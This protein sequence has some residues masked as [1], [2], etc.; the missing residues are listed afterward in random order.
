[1]SATKTAER[2]CTPLTSQTIS[3]HW[4]END[5]AVDQVRVRIWKRRMQVYLPTVLRHYP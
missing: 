2:P 1:M 4:W 5:T 3:V